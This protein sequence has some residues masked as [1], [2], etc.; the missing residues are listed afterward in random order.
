MVRKRGEYGVL[1]LTAVFFISFTLISA[2]FYR[3]A[4]YSGEIPAAESDS[5][6]TLEAGECQGTIYDRNMKPLTN[7]ETK[8]MAA[9]VPAALNREETAQ[10]AVDKEQFYSDFEKGEPFIFQCTDNALESEGLTV[11][12]VPVRY[13]DIQT[14]R[15]VIG[16]LSDNKGVDGIEYAYDSVLRNSF[17]E[18]SVTYTVDGFGN[19]MIGDGKE[20][21]R[22]KAYKSGVVLTIDKDIQE[23]CEKCG[24][25]L[26]KGAIVCADIK[27]GDILAMASFPSYEPDNISEALNDERCPLIDR[28]LYSYSVGSVF[29]LVTAA[30]ALEQGLGGYMYDC[31]GNID[32]DG[33]L[34]NCHK[35]DGHGLQNMSEAM[36]N[37]CNT[38]FIDLSRCLDMGKYRQ[39]ATYLGF[40]KEN[41]LCAGITGSGGVLPT[42]KELNVPAELANFAFGQGKL[43]ATPLQITQ[44]TCAIANNGEMPVLRLIRGLTADGTE[45]G[46]EKNPQLSKVMSEETAKELRQMMILAVRDNERSKAK[47][48]KISAG[49]KTSTAQ[50][51]KFGKNGEELCHAWITG[52]FPARQPKYAVTVLIEDGGYGNDAAA[53]VFRNIAEKIKELNEKS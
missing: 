52:F 36:T 33:K 21:F 44:L 22:T 24:E 34:F 48:R 40:G 17:P 30:S 28:A 11:F 51:G 18:N 14:A 27:N 37:S 47:S 10:Y 26:K 45:I 8:H 6:M 50:T 42:E 41:Y 23:I 1:I 43:T 16:Y 32:V 53:P 20:V 29:K 5:K 12:E 13:S 31:G 3:L 38:Y 4:V 49:A 9:A 25:K 19:I 35:L 7:A 15:H 46:G 2:N 39:M